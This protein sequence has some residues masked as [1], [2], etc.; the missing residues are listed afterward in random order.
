MLQHFFS[1]ILLFVE[2]PRKIDS[3][4]KICLTVKSKLFFEKMVMSS[5]RQPK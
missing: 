4:T 1:A 3:W 2:K 5:V